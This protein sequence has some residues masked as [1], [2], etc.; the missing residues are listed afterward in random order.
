MVNGQG[1]EEAADLFLV[2][3][4]YCSIERELVFGRKWHPER[5]GGGREEINTQR[6]GVHL[7]RGMVPSEKIATQRE[8]WYPVEDLDS[9]EVG[10]W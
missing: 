3:R 9:V 7:V 2:E 6:A 4:Q 1:S 8:A 5:L 10:P